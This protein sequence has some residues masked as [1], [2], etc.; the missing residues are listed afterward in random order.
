MAS[1]VDW[2]KLG[3]R[4]A[5]QG[6]G[7]KGPQAGKPEWLRIEDEVKIRPIGQAV[8]FVKIFVK[9]PQGNRSVIV[10]P[11]DADRAVALLTAEVGYEVRG[12]NRFAMNVIDRADGRIKIFEG[13]MQIFGYWGKWQNTTQ[14]HPGSREGYDWQITSEKTGP[15]PEN[16]KYTPMPIKQTAITTEEWEVIN[17]KKTEYT[18]AEVYKSCPLE[19]VVEFVFAER[20][21]K[22]PNS[23]GPAGNEPAA[24][25]TAAPAANGPIEW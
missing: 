23:S 6:A 16:K 3:G 17:K 18:L 7:R 25:T 9:T 5:T 20:K 1:V 12:N 19:T 4:A 13:G 8:E 10:D 11:E 14:I 15:N 2:N 21:G 24:Q 22:G